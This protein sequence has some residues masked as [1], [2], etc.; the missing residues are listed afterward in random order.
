M[1][2][3]FT[4]RNL[5]LEG[6]RSCIRLIRVSSATTSYFMLLQV[7]TFNYCRVTVVTMFDMVNIG[8]YRLQCVYHLL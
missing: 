2:S 3:V 1:L 6:P 4:E 5:L 8:Y 7:N